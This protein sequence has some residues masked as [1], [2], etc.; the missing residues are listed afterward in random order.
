M[1]GKPSLSQERTELLASLAGSGVSV[2]KMQKQHGF[3]YKTIRRLHPEY[4]SGSGAA[5]RRIDALRIDAEL[6]SLIYEMLDS[7]C[8][9][10]HISETLGAT[11]GQI[12]FLQMDSAWDKSTVGRYGGMV[13]RL[14]SL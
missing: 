11:L 10:K 14:N 12:E 9:A 13:A 1:A 6:S 3:N 7:G 2:K 5:L 4:R 8:S